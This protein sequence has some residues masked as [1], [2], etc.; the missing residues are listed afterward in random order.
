MT[1][2]DLEKNLGPQPIAKIM[3]EHSLKAHDLVA[4]STG[5]LAHKKISHAVK[6]RRL[7]PRMKLKILSALNTVTKK[8]YTLKDLFN[9]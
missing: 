5:Q 6:G 8:N 9:Y 2:T 7:T 4:A 3:A 1:T